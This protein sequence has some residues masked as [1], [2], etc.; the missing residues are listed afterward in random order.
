MSFGALPTSKVATDMLREEVPRLH[1]APSW[2]GVLLAD[3]AA[4]RRPRR[5]RSATSAECRRPPAAGRRTPTD[6]AGRA[7][8]RRSWRMCVLLRLRL[9]W[10]PPSP[11]GQCSSLLFLSGGV[12]WPMS[13]DIS[14]YAVMGAP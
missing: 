10:A 1:H 5:S 11:K 12:R 13:C 6:L 3:E 2:V 14:A 9:L 4:R 8:T 7:P